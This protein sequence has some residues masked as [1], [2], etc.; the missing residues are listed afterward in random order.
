MSMGLA[1]WLLQLAVAGLLL[2]T[3]PFVLRLERELRALRRDRAALESGA[4]GLTEA[5]RMAEAASIR[6]RASAETAGRHVAERL[7]AAEPLRDDLRFLVERA[8][9]LADRLDVAVRAVRPLADQ[10]AAPETPPRPPAPAPA[11][12]SRSL[13]ER[14]LLRALARGPG[15]R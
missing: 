9:I 5:T 11:P 12:S 15:A 2:A 4:Q 6:L 13:A 7:A 10:A 3:L 8:E 14:E 1:E